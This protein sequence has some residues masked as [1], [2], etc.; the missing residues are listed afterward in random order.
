MTD[1]VPTDTTPTA[2]EP[3]QP[4]PAPREPIVVSLNFLQSLSRSDLA[5]RAKEFTIRLRTDGSLHHLVVDQ[6]RFHLQRGD[7]VTADGV[8]DIDGNRGLLRWEKFSFRSCPEDVSVPQAIVKQHNLRVGLK[9]RGRL[10]LPQHREQGLVL[11]SALEIEGKP[12]SEWVTPTDFD[13][14]TA[15]FPDRRIFL[16]TPGHP[17]LGPRAI[18]L[19]A[20]LGMGQ[21]GLIVAPPR[22]G[23]T[24]ILNQ[25]AK[26]IRRNHPAIHLILLLIDERPEEVTDFERS[27]DC[28]IFSS[29]FDESPARHVAL[30]ELVSERAKRLVETGK[31]VVIL[32]D[33]IT[34][35]SRGYNNLQPGKG[36]RTMSG[37][38]D[39]KALAKPKKFFGAARNVEEGGSLTIL[40]TALIETHSRMDDLIFEEYKGTGNMEV[41][42]DRSIAELR[43]FPAIHLTKS[44]TRRD[45]LL[46]HPDELSRIMTLRKQLTELPAVEA[47]EVL[48]ANLQHTKQNAEL[49]LGGLRG[50]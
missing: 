13:K 35:L 16:E 42:L 34:R 11:E 14:L 38:V 8:F 44:G 41:H 29:T 17:D 30:A 36:S 25:L 20:P 43:V 22:A 37:G 24:V 21:R 2:P 23:K 50:I 12:A 10:R 5:A 6:V 40:A 19:L 46:L 9:I 28:D 45:E 32:L 31:D 18:D 39:A 26:A 3:E 4:A 33:S 48:V 47:M 15:M 7:T 1:V 49:L 27:L